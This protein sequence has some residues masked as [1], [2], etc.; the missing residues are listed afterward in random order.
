MVPPCDRVCATRPTPHRTCAH[1]ENSAV[2]SQRHHV[3]RETA[4][5]VDELIAD[6]AV[7]PGSSRQHEEETATHRHDVL[8]ERLALQPVLHSEESLLQAALV[9]DERQPLVKPARAVETTRIVETPS[10]DAV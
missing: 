6:E 1:C 3:R 4:A 7:G 8:L 5:S 10:Q 9:G 2:I